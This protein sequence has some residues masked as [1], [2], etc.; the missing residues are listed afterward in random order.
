MYAKQEGNTMNKSNSIGI[1]VYEVKTPRGADLCKR[2]ERIYE[3]R[4]K[5]GEAREKI[6][7]ELYST[8]PEYKRVVDDIEKKITK[9]RPSL[10]EPNLLENILDQIESTIILFIILSIP[11]AITADVYFLVEF[12]LDHWN[13]NTI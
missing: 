11:I 2:I 4:M 8:D 6:H 3:E 10:R 13:A 12:F 1:P 7:L 9:W 5:R